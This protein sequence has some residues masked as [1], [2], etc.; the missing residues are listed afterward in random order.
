[1][2]SNYYLLDDMEKNFPDFN[3]EEY[4]EK[5]EEELI[6]ICRN[7]YK[8]N[9]PVDV[10]SWIRV[11]EPDER[12][13]YKNGLGHQVC[14]FR[15]TIMRGL[16]YKCCC[17]EYEHDTYDE[18]QPIVVGTH[19]SKSVL[20]PVMEIE[21]KKYDVT[22]TARYNFY[23]WCISIESSR[24][25]NFDHMGLITDQKGYFEGFP[26]NKIYDAFEK[27]KYNYSF[28]I[29][30]DYEFYTLMYLLRVHLTNLEAEKEWE[31]K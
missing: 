8:Q 13:I 18:F 11:N 28:C 10:T 4:E 2:N 23:D 31:K 19:Y 14:F 20:L 9:L 1:M 5:S 3:R 26:E 30:N 25:L 24:E 17:G 29:N 12:L 16:F 27:N 7:Y 22:I 15:D 21:L 6:T